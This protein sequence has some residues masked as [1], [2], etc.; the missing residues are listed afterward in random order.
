MLI[1]AVDNLFKKNIG[2]FQGFLIYN[3][4]NNKD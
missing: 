3:I 2:N 1:L 4:N